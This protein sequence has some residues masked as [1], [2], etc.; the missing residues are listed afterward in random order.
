MAGFGVGWGNQ[1]DL[2]F[3]SYTT[4]DLFNQVAQDGQSW[5]SVYSPDKTKM[6]VLG[7]ANNAIYQYTIT[8]GDIKTA[9]YASLSLSVAAQTTSPRGLAIS[10]DGTKL[11]VASS[12]NTTIYQYTLPT[13][14]SL[15]GASYSGLSFSTSGQITNLIGLR[16]SAD[17]TKL[18]ACNTNTSNSKIYQYTLSTAW[19]IN[20]A[21]YASLAFDVWAFSGTQVVSLDFSKSGMCLFFLSYED[22]TVY[23]M[24]LNAPYSFSSVTPRNKYRL[25]DRTNSNVMSIV[26]SSDYQWMYT[27]ASA[28]QFQD[29]II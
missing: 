14:Y 22:A 16:F 26:F 17:G 8:D 24:D 27:V 7:T 11:Y 13:A 10:S 5:G 21:S 9:T 19:A 1:P 28:I 20:T 25:P 2:N 29:K 23:Q 15:S 12:S 3:A 18:F 4:G 6:F